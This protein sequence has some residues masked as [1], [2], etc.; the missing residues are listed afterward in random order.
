VNQDVRPGLSERHRYRAANSSGCSSYQC[1]FVFER[2]H[3]IYLPNSVSQRFRL[4]SGEDIGVMIL[5]IDQIWPLD[6]G[7]ATVNE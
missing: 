1:S 5:L 2:R 6:L 7:S 4:P 3:F